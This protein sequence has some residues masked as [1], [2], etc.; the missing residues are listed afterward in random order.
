[1]TNN[2]WFN[3]LQSDSEKS[4]KYLQQEHIK[5]MNS[6]SEAFV[7]DI[8]NPKS[9]IS[10]KMKEAANNGY[11]GVG[12]DVSHGE[13]LRENPCI[14]TKTDE[15]VSAVDKRLQTLPN[16][17]LRVYKPACWDFDDCS[18]MIISWSKSKPE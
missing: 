6:A 15:F 3:N 10:Q 8:L 12:V 4:I 7:S 5:C 17:N 18:D 11:T 9:K 13:F 2:Y 16:S 14:W 1:M